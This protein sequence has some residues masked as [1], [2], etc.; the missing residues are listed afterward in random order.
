MNEETKKLFEQEQ[1]KPD[2]IEKPAEILEIL[3]APTMIQRKINF[4]KVKSLEDVINI[5]DVLNVTFMGNEEQFK[6]ID[7]LLEDVNNG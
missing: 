5:L 2:T 4:D 6:K 7:Y 3:Q 1:E